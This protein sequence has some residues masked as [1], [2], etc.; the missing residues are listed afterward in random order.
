MKLTIDC[1]ITQPIS[2]LQSSSALALLLSVAKIS[3]TEFPLETLICRQFNLPMQQDYPI[4]ALA[5]AADGLDTGTAYWLRAD[6][7]Y[8][9]LQRDCFSLAEPYPLLV[10]Q[11]HAALL[12]QTLNQHFK[13]DGLEFLIGQSGAWY[14][15]SEQALDIETFLP[16]VVAGKNVHAYLPQGTM[17]AKMRAV[18]N[19]VQMLL[20]EHEV[21]VARESVG[22]LAINSVWFSGGGVMPIPIKS[23][24]LVIVAGGV[25]YRG[26]AI[27][28][29]VAM[30]DTPKTAD[31][32]L[33]LINH[34]PET[35]LQLT[36]TE[37]LEDDW[38]GSVLAMIKNRK[39]NQLILNL[40]V[41]ESTVTA[42]IKPIDVVIS[43]FLF[44]RK[45]KAVLDYLQ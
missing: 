24:M 43:S 37:V 28:S 4:A 40:G 5:A 32:F 9:V 26:L 31:D 19:E 12:V 33:V 13:Q 6:P 44:W 17:A 29:G 41:G 25:F 7:V 20:H 42:V 39:I 30:Q 21:N 36:D 23:P 14:L 22:K 16:S 11:G 15:R 38:F 34:Y 35:R 2:T 1:Q 27:W 10:D 8:L 3:Q 18:L 45:P